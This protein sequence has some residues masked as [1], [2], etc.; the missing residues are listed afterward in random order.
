MTTNIE[1]SSVFNWIS[2]WTH[3]LIFTMMIPATW[4][5]P[6]WSVKD[7]EYCNFLFGDSLTADEVSNTGKHSFLDF[8]IFSPGLCFAIAPSPSQPDCPAVWGEAGRPLLCKPVQA[9]GGP[10][11]LPEEV[12]RVPGSQQPGRPLAAS[13]STQEEEAIEWG[14][15]RP[16]HWWG[17]SW[18]GGGRG[19]RS[20]MIVVEI[21]SILL[22]RNPMCKLSAEDVL[23]LQ[24]PS[25]LPSQAVR[26]KVRI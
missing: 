10:D 17:E 24:F 25:S 14:R 7:R 1:I 21:I 8:F 16:C 2:M 5:I 3:L 20:N 11:S 15:T 22:G 9:V 13:P 23:F 26:F 4:I 19:D 18:G 6:T 12:S